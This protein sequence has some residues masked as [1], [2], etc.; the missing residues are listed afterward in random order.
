MI[1][2]TKSLPPLRRE[3]LAIY[4]ATPDRQ[5][6]IK[7]WEGLSEHF[8]PLTTPGSFWRFNRH[9][10]PDDPEQGWKLHI[11]ATVHS[12]A[13]ALR[14][15]APY[16]VNQNVMFKAPTSLNQLSNLNAGVHYGFSQVGKVITVYPRT[17][18]EAVRL[19]RHLHRLTAGL[20]A[21]AV[22][23]DLPFR[24]DSCVYYRYGA[25]NSLTI[26]QSDGTVV[27]ALRDQEGN[28]TPDRREPGAAVPAWLIDPFLKSGGLKP[29]ILDSPLRNTFMAFE[30]LSQR[31]K[32]G[33][34]KA[35]DLRNLPA[36]LCVLKE[37]RRHGE[38]AW[39]GR[40]GN[41]RI[42]NEARV[43]TTL[44]HAGIEVPVVHASFEV[45]GHY[46]V[47]TEF[48]AGKNLQL[49]S[50]GP[51]RLRIQKVVQY[52]LQL[53]KIISKIHAAG[54]VWR[55]CKPLNV[56][57]TADDALRPIDFEGACSATSGDEAPWGTEGYLA[58][59]WYTTNGLHSRKPEDLYA[60]G[61]TLYQLVCGHP[62]KSGL[63]RPQKL[64]RRKVPLPLLEVIDALLDSVPHARPDASQVVDALAALN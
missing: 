5:I 13:E 28:L 37:G 45:E 7:E 3:S 18:T 15:V 29:Q 22:P 12:A 60:L 33:V 47:V 64:T 10:G 26:K 34:Y 59:E 43:L 38:T 6:R 36:C 30:A 42:R 56:I 58:P 4:Y 20:P 31:G 21:P 35:L 2:A 62:P 9:P 52:A 11:S 8:L 44:R 39:D 55:D 53:A 48:I 1:E 63:P 16:L 40:D 25:F 14:R 57:V 46:Y 54:W 17:T 51:R 19:A 49:V 50:S 41:W 24:P 61:A 27:Y 23:Y 32:G